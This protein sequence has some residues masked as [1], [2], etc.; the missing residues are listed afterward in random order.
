MNP[1]I[2]GLFLLVCACFVAVLALSFLS[3]GSPIE[4]QMPLVTVDMVKENQDKIQK[5]KEAKEDAAAARK[6]FSLFTRS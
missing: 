2:K 4:V 6:R 5:A 1:K 3:K